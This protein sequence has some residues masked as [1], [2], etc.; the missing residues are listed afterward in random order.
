MVYSSKVY[1]N[2]LQHSGYIKPKLVIRINT[3][4]L[5]P[6][7]V[8]RKLDEVPEHI[9]ADSARLKRRTSASQETAITDTTSVCSRNS[10][11]DVTFYDSTSFIR[12]L[13]QIPPTQ[14]PF[15]L[16]EKAGTAEKSQSDDNNQ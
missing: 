2:R 8:F 14:F 15:H 10:I 1:D 5:I 3:D 7:S 11:A 6:D 16:A 4:N 12:N 13:R 9:R